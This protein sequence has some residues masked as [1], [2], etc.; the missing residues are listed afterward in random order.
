MK[1]EMKKLKDRNEIKKQEKGRQEASYDLIQFEFTWNDEE[2]E[3]ELC[4]TKKV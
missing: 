4:R 3:T 1:L 2:K